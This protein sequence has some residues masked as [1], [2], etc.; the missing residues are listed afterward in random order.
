MQQNL[1]GFVIVK[2]KD[3]L[4]KI[5]REILGD[6]GRWDEIYNL[7]KCTI[8]PDPSLIKIGQK[9]IL[10]NDGQPQKRTT[11]S[12]VEFVIV[13]HKDSLSKIAKEFL[14]D[15]QR[16]DEIYNLNKGT[17]GPDPNLLKIG[18]KVML[19]KGASSCKLKPLERSKD[20][21]K[22]YKVGTIGTLGNRDN[23]QAKVQ[24]YNDNGIRVARKNYHE[25][26]SNE[27]RGLLMCQHPN[28][29]NILSASP[30]RRTFMME[31]ADG[32]R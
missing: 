1:S 25:N 23:G 15:E 2:Y 32:I 11:Q 22:A 8:G 24:E 31:L 17:I 16:W 28:I 21:E 3:S 4:S 12:F 14:G 26:I 19:P 20:C 18:Q 30:D 5:A 9:L 29:I 7:N 13:K 6:E 27:I 10:P